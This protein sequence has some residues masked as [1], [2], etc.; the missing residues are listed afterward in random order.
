MDLIDRQATIERLNHSKPEIGEDSSKERYRYLQWLADYNAIK[1]VPSAQPTHTTQSNTLDALDV[2]D[3]ISRQAAIDAVMD[4]FKRV[5]TTAIRA[6][7][8]L[9]SLPSAQPQWIPVAERL[10]E[11]CNYYIVTDFDKVDEA[12]YNSDGRWFSWDGN[13]LKDVTAWQPL[14]E[15]WRGEET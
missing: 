2:L 14:P 12:Y 8:R 10:P 13:K 5:P 7:A 9:E 4:E 11:R 1:E 6:K 15:P 3:C